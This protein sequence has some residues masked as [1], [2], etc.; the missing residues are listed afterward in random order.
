MGGLRTKESHRGD[1]PRLC[2][3]KLLGRVGIGSRDG[4]GGRHTPDPIGGA[5]ET[6]APFRAKSGPG[7]R[8]AFPSIIFFVS[9]LADFR[10]ERIIYWHCIIVVAG[11]FLYAKHRNFPDGKNRFPPD[12]RVKPFLV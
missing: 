11:G 3:S 8:F 7:G 6:E 12:Y 1:P 9:R 5:P 10:G 4:H 2:G